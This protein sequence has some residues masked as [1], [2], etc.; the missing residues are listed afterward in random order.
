MKLL[1]GLL[2]LSF[3]GWLAVNLVIQRLRRLRGEPIPERK[4]PRTVTY[5]CIGLVA[6]Y[7]LLILWRVYNEGFSAFG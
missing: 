3:L 5:V 6:I 4:G 2:L 1:F 7:A